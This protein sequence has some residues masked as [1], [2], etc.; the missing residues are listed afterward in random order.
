MKPEKKPKQIFSGDEL[1]LKIR[2]VLDGMSE[3]G[4]I[5]NSEE[6]FAEFICRVQHTLG[7]EDKQLEVS[8]LKDFPENV[9]LY[10]DSG[11]WQMRTEDLGVVILQQKINEPESNFINRCKALRNPDYY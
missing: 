3:I 6:F 5:P 8:I 9:S 2:K 1:H 7:I 11:L 10:K 4:G